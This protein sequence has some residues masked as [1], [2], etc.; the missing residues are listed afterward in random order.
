MP[1]TKRRGRLT[2]ADLCW[3]IE[4][5]LLPAANSGKY[6]SVS[7]SDLRALARWIAG[8]RGWVGD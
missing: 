7:G 4:V 1:A 8:L 5:G 3:A 2:Y 6:Y